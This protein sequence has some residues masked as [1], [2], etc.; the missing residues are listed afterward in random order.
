MTRDK[1]SVFD[2]EEKQLLRKTMR[3]LPAV[4][5]SGAGDNGMDFDIL[6]PTIRIQQPQYLAIRN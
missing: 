3:L 2:E 4:Q 6:L 1:T 5:F